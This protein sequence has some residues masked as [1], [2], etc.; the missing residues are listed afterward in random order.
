MTGNVPFVVDDFIND[1]VQRPLLSV[2][3]IDIRTEAKR[4]HI[5]CFIYQDEAKRST[6]FSSPLCRV[7]PESPRWLLHKDRVAEAELVIGNAAKRNKVPAPEVIFRAVES[8]CHM[9]IRCF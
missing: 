2:I 4:V 8:S 1:S 7:I 5:T 3:G 9:V 6:L